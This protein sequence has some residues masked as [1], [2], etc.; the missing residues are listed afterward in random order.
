[1]KRKL[2]G[3]ADRPGTAGPAVVGWQE[4]PR[5]C[6][7]LNPGNALEYQ[8]GD[9]RSFR[10]VWD[11]NLCIHCLRCWIFCPDDSI[12]VRDGTMVGIDYD[13]CKGCGICA[14]ECPPKV[15]AIEMQKESGA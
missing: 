14:R 3:P 15:G 11:E 13:H 2:N 10:P 6:V 5:G 1:M 7:I 4:M 8:T 9:W 12:V